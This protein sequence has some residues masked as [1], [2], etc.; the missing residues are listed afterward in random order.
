M[1]FRLDPQKLMCTVC[2]FCT[3]CSVKL[4][5]DPDNNYKADYEKC[6]KKVKEYKE[7]KQKY[8]FE[9]NPD[10]TGEE[11]NLY[12]ETLVLE[13]D[14]AQNLALPRLNINSH[15]YKRILNL[16]VFNIHCFNDSDSK[17]F[18]FLES[19]GKKDYNS[20]CSFLEDFIE[21][22][23]LDNPNL[24]KIVLFSDSAAGQNKNLTMVKFCTWLSK[25]Y[26]VDIYACI[27]SAWSQLCQCVQKNS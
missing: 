17:M 12:E 23:L 6:L 27:S 13:F 18:C 8:V 2:D 25:T 11:K 14:Y 22:K 15:Y 7:L 24:K 20:V 26:S 19:D 21:K 10:N 5:V 9:R 16:Y 3:Q 1:I 4:L